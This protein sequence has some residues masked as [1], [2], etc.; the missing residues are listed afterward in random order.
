MSNEPNAVPD[1]R[2]VEPI[3]VPRSDVVEEAIAE[4]LRHEHHESNCDYQCWMAR[5]LMVPLVAAL[6]AA[7]Q[8]PAGAR[9]QMFSWSH[10]Q[11]C[12]DNLERHIAALTR[13]LATARRGLTELL[14]LYDWRNEVGGAITEDE[15]RK[16]GREKKAAWEAVRKVLLNIPD[17][18]GCTVSDWCA[19]HLAAIDAPATEAAPIPPGGKC[20]E[21]NATTYGTREVHMLNC[22]RADALAGEGATRTP[23]DAP[24][25]HAPDFKEGDCEARDCHL[26]PGVAEIVYGLWEAGVQTATSC[27]GGGPEK[28]HGRL[29]R[30]VTL[31]WNDP[32]AGPAAYKIAKSLGMPAFMLQQ[33]WPDGGCGR[34]EGA[35]YWEIMFDRWTP[36]TRST[37]AAPPP[38][39][40]NTL[41]VYLSTACHHGK[42]SECRKECKFCP[43]TCGCGCHKAGYGS[44]VAPSLEPVNALP[45]GYG[46]CCDCD[47]NAHYHESA[48]PHCAKCGWPPFDCDGHPEQANAQGSEAACREHN[49]KCCPSHC[50]KRH[51]CKYGHDCCPVACGV[52]AQEH[53][54]EACGDDPE[55]A[56]GSPFTPEEARERA[57][58]GYLYGDEVER[59]AATL[60]SYADLIERGDALERAA[61]SA[62]KLLYRVFDFT[63]RTPETDAT[64]DNLRSALQRAKENR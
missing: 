32:L 8:H 59:I 63:K 12:S 14:R 24:H 51:G 61:E 45:V 52:I 58:N 50:C 48:T 27:E 3:D 2:S 5:K 28:N 49:H 30:I 34:G 62:L 35:F 18:C 29:E 11:R 7:R 44:E 20:P 22:S 39:P 36:W 53:P 15:A 41:H 9:C 6:T 1:Q 4:A 56:P 23:T 47:A 17:D 55:P 43:A 21:C 37:G 10:G 16:Y 13:K 40:A 31:G 38:E 25:L 46:E 19:S 54:C 60:R 42:H 33:C 57:A 64:L 26:D